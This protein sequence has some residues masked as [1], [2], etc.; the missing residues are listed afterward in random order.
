VNTHG[1][2]AGSP[3]ATERGASKDEKARGFRFNDGMYTRLR[4]G[5]TLLREGFIEVLGGDP[6]IFESSMDVG[7]L[8]SVIEGVRNVS[9]DQLMNRMVFVGYTDEGE[10]TRARLRQVLEEGGNEFR[11]DFLNFVTGLKSLP[12]A[13]LNE[14]QHISV[15]KPVGQHDSLPHTHTCSWQLDLPEYTSIE[16]MKA[17]L[18]IAVKEIDLLEP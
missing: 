7:G 9:V 3:H 13:G 1:D 11:M 18:E 10:A 12:A 8:I 2:S 17:K 14:V 5:F 4:L 6:D 15:L 16:I